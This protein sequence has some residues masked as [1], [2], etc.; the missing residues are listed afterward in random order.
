MSR[1]QAA[2]EDAH[3]DLGIG[4]HREASTQNQ[5]IVGAYT[6]WCD[7]NSQPA[8]PSDAPDAPTPSQVLLRYLHCNSQERGWAH[9]TCS[10][11]SLVVA[12]YVMKHGHDDPRDVRVRAWLKARLRET[13][14]RAQRPVDA[15]T[16]DEVK[17]AAA[18]PTKR[19]SAHLS[20]RRALI[21]LADLLEEAELLHAN[22]MVAGRDVITMR[23]L[24][25][26]AFD[27]GEERIRV[28]IKN[29]VLTILRERTPVHFE[30]VRTALNEADGRTYPLLPDDSDDV[31]RR[32]DDRTADRSLMHQAL[33]RLEPTLETVAGGV[34]VS[35]PAAAAWWAA[36]TRAQRLRL[37]AR[38]DGSLNER[39]QDLAYFL[40]GVV[41]MH[42]HAELARLT[43]GHMVPR[44]G[45]YDY[46]LEQHKGGEHAQRW[47]S[48]VK[49]IHGALDH[50]ADD[51]QNCPVTC[52]ACAMDNHL[53]LRRE[54]GGQDA[55]PLFISYVGTAKGQ[56]LHTAAGRS[57]LRRYAELIG[58][59]TNEDGSA[60]RISSRS[61]RVTAATLL[62]DAGASYL[63]LM[64]AG[65]WSS[66]L[67][68]ALYVRRNDAWSGTLVLP[69]NP[70]GEQ[71][72][73]T[74]A[75][76]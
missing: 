66:P 24:Q 2:R 39:V 38:L 6:R 13:G 48:K 33:R 72:A 15:L 21:A 55:D 62:R 44:A 50:A 29:D 11:V 42:R 52:P 8:L 36:S 51:P 73:T 34:Q 40:T 56:V 20:R 31:H 59:T 19:S 57:I 63:E 76:A 5:Y 46:T 37:M 53:A 35:T 65:S 30:A 71:G 67:Y 28:T 32:T 54:D 4:P 45:G 70:T 25:A 7:A 23:H 10:H 9:G 14:K 58:A 60:R 41:N 69:M 75:P 43:L 22:P 1:R 12:Q 27:V 49:P 74:T 61:M 47:G 18:T 16:L 17:T 68:A 64:E 3:Q 26:D